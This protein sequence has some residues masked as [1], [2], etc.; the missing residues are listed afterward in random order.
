M[1][2]ESSSGGTHVNIGKTVSCRGRNAMVYQ[3]RRRH[4]KERDWGFYQKG[5][6][7]EGKKKKNGKTLEGNSVNYNG[8][9]GAKQW[10]QGEPS[11]LTRFQSTDQKK[12]ICK[13]RGK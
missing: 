5:K 1:G 2:C 7:P 3:K 4:E 10:R 9:Q 11:S 8:R 13:F 6:S 12:G